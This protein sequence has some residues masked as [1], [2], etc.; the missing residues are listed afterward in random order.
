MSVRKLTARIFGSIFVLCGIASAHAEHPVP[1]SDPYDLES[2]FRWF[3]PIY[4]ADLEDMTPKQRANTGWFATYDRLNLYGSRPQIDR[5][6]Y[7]Q[8]AENNLDKGWGH[9]Y[10]VGYMLADENH[11]W[12]FSYM[13]ADVIAYHTVR[14]E[15]L[16]RINEDELDGEATNPKPPFGEEAIPGISNN[17][18]YF[19][20]FIDES[21]SENDID[22]DSWEI[23]KTWR[24]VP[25]HYGGRLE[26][27]V[28]ARWFRIR[29]TFKDATFR[30]S[31]LNPIEP[32]FPLDPLLWGGGVDQI[33]YEIAR[34][35]NEAITVQTG[36]R[37][38]KH[39]DRFLFSTDFRVF[40]GMN[41]QSS[42]YSNSWTTTVYEDDD[43]TQGDEVERIIYQETD[44]IYLSNNEF[45]LGFDARG[46][47]AYQLTKAITIRGGIQVLDIARGLWRGGST[48]NFLI[49]EEDQDYIAFGGTFGITLNR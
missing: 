41:F 5:D 10:E 8:R 3:E 34:T 28:G 38:F 46:E 20:R 30:S 6:A 40:T 43:P 47:I 13:D 27:M 32:V 35:D 33:Q 1:P 44:P 22:I 42:R 18:G 19:Y 17:P 25:Y 7:P 9:R 15:A 26:P 16:N 48:G 45:F 39:R 2:D 14:H 37:Y 4:Q 36:F 31:R 23:S 49:G 11:G 24:M 29:D 21:D 12:L